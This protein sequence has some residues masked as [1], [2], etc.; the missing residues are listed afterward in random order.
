MK[1]RAVQSIER[2]EFFRALSPD[3]LARVRHRVNQRALVRQQAIYFEGHPADRLWVVQSGQVRLYKSS[4]NGQV[5]TLD[6]L[7]PGEVFGAVFSPAGDLFSSSAEAVVDGSAWWVPQEVFQ[8]ELA[9]EPGLGVD[10]VQILSRR[11]RDAH[12]RLRSLAHDPAPAR[13]ALALLRAARDGE[14]WGT[15]RALAEV[16]GTSV[17]TTIRILRG[18]E[19]KGLVEGEVGCVRI[20]DE[21]ALQDIAGG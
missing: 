4:S 9:E 15:R 13:I 8:R 19:R 17:E 18:F 3:R 12:D 6:V 14:V 1:S 11:L 20:I 21:G 16:A 7:G 5:T 10:I 2:S